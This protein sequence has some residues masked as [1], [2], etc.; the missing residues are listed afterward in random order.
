MLKL[1]FLPT[2]IA[3][4]F[5]IASGGATF[6]RNRTKTYIKEGMSQKEAEAQAFLDFR[7]TAEESQQ[8]SRPDR[9]SKQQAGPLGRIILAFANTPAQYARIMQKAASDL[10]NRRGDDKTNMS[11]IMYYG[12]IQNV[13]FNAL[14]QALFA[15][16]FAD[17]EPDEEKKNKK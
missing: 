2:Q 17:E 8:S 16:A 1:G 5:A 15:M 12:F 11:K 6:F 9:I 13:I 4:S 7:E 10:K 3:D 14:Q